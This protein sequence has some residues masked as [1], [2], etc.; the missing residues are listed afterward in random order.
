MAVPVSYT[1]DEFADYLK[2]EVL[3]DSADG[4]GFGDIIPEI[5][6]VTA[7]VIIRESGTPPYDFTN[8]IPIYEPGF[9]L[10]VGASLT[11]SN[12]VTRTLNTALT[13]TSTLMTINGLGG[14][15]NPGDYANIVMRNA[16]ARVRNSIYAAVT[17]EVLISMGLSDITEVNSMNIAL[18]RA[19][20]RVE[21]LRKVMQSI[22]GNYNYNMPVGGKLNTSSVY[23]QVIRMFQREQSRLNGLL[24]EAG[25]LSPE[26]PDESLSY[27][28]DVAVVW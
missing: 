6:Q 10:P 28:G 20:G 23:T 2:D 4:L 21:L 19:Y 11:W 8:D 14:N 26:V 1:Y 24:A 27:S 3:L 16:V 13:P 22:A 9:S 25:T 12:G 17:D 18:F 15:F 7:R 5:P